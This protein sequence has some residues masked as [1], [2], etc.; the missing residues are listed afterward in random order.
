M[1]NYLLNMFNTSEFKETISNFLKFDSNNS[2][3][4]KRQYSEF[5]SWLNEQYHT[6]SGK[7]SPIFI[8]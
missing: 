2:Q 3:R 5:Y 7:T 1:A 4:L 6:K 8:W